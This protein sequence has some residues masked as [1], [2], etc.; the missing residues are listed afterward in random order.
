MNSVLNTYRLFRFKTVCVIVNVY[1]NVGFLFLS[2]PLKRVLD[3]MAF[4][5]IIMHLLRV[6]TFYPKTIVPLSYP[7]R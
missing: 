3:V 6:K 1:V 4:Y 5:P 7:R 2:E